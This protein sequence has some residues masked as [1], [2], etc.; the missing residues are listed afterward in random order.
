MLSLAEAQQGNGAVVLTIGG[1]LDIATAPELRARVA[2]VM[3][4]GARRLVLDLR[5]VTFVD[6]TALAVFV[7]ARSR[8]AEDGQIA[9]VIAPDSYARLILEVTGLVGPLNVV[10]TLEDAI[11]QVAA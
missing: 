8:L 2:A 5:A 4:A 10:E 7:G 9:L 1:E 6:S 11:D 3:D